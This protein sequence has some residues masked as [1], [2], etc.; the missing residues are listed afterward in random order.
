MRGAGQS[1]ESEPVGRQGPPAFISPDGFV[2]Q[3]PKN[4]RHLCSAPLVFH[5]PGVCA[6]ACA[7]ECV[8]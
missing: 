3:T 8:S 4:N 7:C 5:T 2:L 1:R 6:C